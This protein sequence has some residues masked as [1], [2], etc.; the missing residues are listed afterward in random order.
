MSHS[1]VSPMKKSFYFVALVSVL[2][3]CMAAQKKPVQLFMAGDSTMADKPLTKPALDTVTGDSVQELFLERGWGQLLPEFFN[4][5]V[6][7]RNFAQN[8]RST[9]RFIR[10]GWWDKLI[11]DLKKGDYVVIQ[12]AHNDGAKDKPDRYTTPEEYE[13]NLIRMISDVR[14]KGANPILCTSVMRRKFDREGRLVD[15]HG[16]YPVLTRKVAKELHVPCIDMQKMT[17]EWLE[18]EGVEASASNF[19]QL[20]PG[21]SRLFPAGLKDNT[22]FRE[23][24]ARKAASFFVEGLKN[25]KMK[26]LTKYLRK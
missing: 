25:E 17:T 8:G 13:A 24:G 6:V 12:F 3:L 18:S 23:K 7:V 9:N 21:T 16:V 2:F 14:K 22:H 26:G 5:G 15:T 11:A 1:N 20:E 4:E 19:H 10:E